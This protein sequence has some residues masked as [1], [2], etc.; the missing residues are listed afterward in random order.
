MNRYQHNIISHLSADEYRREGLGDLV[1][2]HHILSDT[3][4]ED[5]VAHRVNEYLE[6]NPRGY[7]SDGIQR[8]RDS[9]GIQPPAPP[10]PETRTIRVT[11]DIETPS[12]LRMLR[13]GSEYGF[14][15]QLC[16][17]LIARGVGHSHRGFVPFDITAVRVVT[18]PTST[19]PD[20]VTP[21][22]GSYTKASFSDRELGI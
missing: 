14:S 17:D 22:G 4:S 5:E 18:D 21:W 6:R 1:E 3:L 19:P 2:H 11:L 9:T 7:C 15:R 8:F 16:A 12:N 13:G 10:A 20:V